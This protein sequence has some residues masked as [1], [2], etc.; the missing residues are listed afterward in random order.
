MT[1]QCFLLLF[2]SLVSIFKFIL[3]QHILKAL[4]D[5]TLTSVSDKRC[6]QQYFDPQHDVSVSFSIYSIC[7][8]SISM[9]SFGCFILVCHGIRDKMII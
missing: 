3:N 8:L 5:L 6:R 9:I 1:I 4:S 7:V 2:I